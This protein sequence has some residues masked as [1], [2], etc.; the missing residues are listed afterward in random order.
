LD[1]H[2][3]RAMSTQEEIKA[4]MGIHQE[5]TEAPMHSIRSELEET[6]GWTT[7]VVSRTKT[8]RLRKDLSEKID[9]TELDLQAVKTS[10]NMWT[11]ILKD[12]ITDRKKNFHKDVKNTRNDLYEELD[13]MFQVEVRA[14][15]AELMIDQKIMEAIRREFQTQLKEDEAEA[16]R[17]K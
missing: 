11:G 9:E 8:Q 1:N 14:I 10:V 13:L 6:I 15:K 7:S 5:M 4:K 17:G 12:N 3:A 16:E 2:H